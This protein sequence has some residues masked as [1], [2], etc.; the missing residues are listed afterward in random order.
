MDDI[1]PFEPSRFIS[2]MLGTCRSMPI[3]FLYDLT[4][5]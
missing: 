1:E 2:K 5:T 3:S 4:L